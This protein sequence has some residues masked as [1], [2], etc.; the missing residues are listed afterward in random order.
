[1]PA[2]GTTIDALFDGRLALE[3]P[4]RA[5]RVAIDAVFLAA[6]VPAEAGDRVL[7]F[8]TGVGSAALCL[9]FRV[10]DCR[11]V[12]IDRRTDVIALARANAMRAGL[13][14]RVSFEP[15]DVAAPVAGAPFD[16]IMANPPFFRAGQ[17]RISP[18]PARAAARTEAGTTLADWI[19]AAL[20]AVRIG[21]SITFIHLAERLDELLEGLRRGAGSI[22]VL[23]LVPK[24][25]A[26]A[27][28]VVV[29]AVKGA[30]GGTVIAPGFV[31]HEADRRYTAAAAAVLRDAAPVALGETR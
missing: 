10:P 4:R 19:A 23:P 18:D 1:M 6:A 2:G 5:D 20:A 26:P 29:R 7:D 21:G 8:G 9:A 14:A 3:Q 17:G 13:A 31:L 15:G 11:V 24:P 22:A 28:R 16:H 12:G 27:G 30:A 25:G